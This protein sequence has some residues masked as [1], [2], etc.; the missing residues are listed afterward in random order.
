MCLGPP[1]ANASPGPW[2]QL[3]RVLQRP[4]LWSRPSLQLD[5]L[6]LPREPG[7]L[8][9]ISHGTEMGVSNLHVGC[10]MSH[11]F[12]F[13][14]VCTL[15]PMQLEVATCRMYVLSV[16]IGVSNKRLVCLN[17]TSALLRTAGCVHHWTIWGFDNIQDVKIVYSEKNLELTLHRLED[18]ISCSIS[19]LSWSL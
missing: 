4:K 15:S 5:R 17:G 6:K 8:R 1:Y 13:G 10:G 2:R 19:N 11:G 14:A 16:G 7:R 9:K 18:T 3:R 12:C